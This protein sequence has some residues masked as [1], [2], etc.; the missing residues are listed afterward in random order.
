MKDNTYSRDSW[1]FRL[2]EII[3]EAD[4]PAGK[5]F[6]VS[7]LIVI[8]VSVI[9]VALES[10]S[11]I[12]QAYGTQLR[13]LEWVITI[14]F[15][16][17]YVLRLMSVG[18]PLRYARSFF[19]IVDVLSILPTYLSLFFA[20]TQ[21][22]LVIR[23][24]RLLRVFRVLK[25]GHFLSEASLLSEAL[26][27]SGRKITVFLGTVLSLV[28]IVGA[29]MYLI[30]GPEHGFT[31]IPQSIYWAVVTLTTVGYGDIAP[32]TVMGKLFASVV[33]I[34]GYGIIAVPTGIVSVELA[35]TM[36][37]STRQAACPECGGEGHSDKADFCM[38]CGGAL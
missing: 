14:L 37:T 35:N 38:Y 29:L 11:S 28:L 20:G 25:L 6:D 5:A 13:T 24:L 33:M 30:E 23:A 22:L 3:F 15:T 21:A 12:S 36:Q 4:T 16:I 26:R 31:S 18:K 19:G 34:L 1:Q 2:H 10:V 32:Q 17:E 9:T 27:A 7:L 8:V